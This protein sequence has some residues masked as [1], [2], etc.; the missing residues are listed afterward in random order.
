MGGRT[1]TVIATVAATTAA[2]IA[3]TKL[4]LGTRSLLAPVLAD[5]PLNSV[6]FG[7]AWATQDTRPRTEAG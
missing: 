7:L 5:A 2:G 3:L 4:R 1:A 6:A